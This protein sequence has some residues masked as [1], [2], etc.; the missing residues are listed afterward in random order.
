MIQ[1]ADITD[2][3]IPEG[4]KDENEI[5]PKHST[6]I[7]SDTRQKPSEKN[8]R[9]DIRKQLYDKT[10]TGVV[11][12]HSKSKHSP[13]SSPKHN[14]SHNSTQR[15]NSLEL[16][17]IQNQRHEIQMLVAELRERDKELNEMVTAHQKQLL[18]W[19]QDR[20]RLLMLEQKCRHYKGELMN[21]TKQLE[22]ATTRLEGLE[23]QCTSQLESNKEKITLL[24]EEKK[25]KNNLVLSLEDRNRSLNDSLKD[26]SCT[27]GQMAAREQELVTLLKL[28]G[29]ELIDLGELNKELSSRYQQL[30]AHNSDCLKRERDAFHQSKYW[31]EKYNQSLQDI[32]KLTVDVQE[33]D[34][35]LTQQ[36]AQISEAQHH[37][38]A[39]QEALIV[40]N[41]REKCK[42]ELLTSLKTK[43][44]RSMSELRSVRELFE[45]QQRELTLLQLN[46]N[47]SAVEQPSMLDISVD[48]PNIP[49]SDQ[50][51]SNVLTSS[52]HETQFIKISFEDRLSRFLDMDR[53]SPPTKGNNCEEK[54]LEEVNL[55][56]SIEIYQEAVN[57][58]IDSSPG[59]KLQRLLTE[60][61][62]MIESLER[63]TQPVGTHSPTLHTRGHY[64][65][66]SNNSNE[67]TESMH[68]LQVNEKTP[69]KDQNHPQHKST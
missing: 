25:L 44:E 32:E 55:D 58:R 9:T 43:Q 46:H 21:R 49:V 67:I 18:S 57:K 17:T 65:N 47:F 40:S 37:M 61:K 53:H 14:T 64:R 3:H 4:E 29:R 11:S 16:S 22:R 51:V 8:K 52:Q 23:G 13:T 10:H 59:S 56:E 66:Q 20:Q 28:K 45:R 54:D 60:S 41:D 39:L 31:Q 38:I 34:D 6:P 48:D 63:S 30:E 62:N 24:C 33:R 1:L 7:K 69:D 2:I 36:I 50:S 42:D 12:P 15:T 26:V 68:D 35:V 27:V 19:E 5:Y